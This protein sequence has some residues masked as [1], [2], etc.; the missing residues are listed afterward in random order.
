M[1]A[2]ESAQIFDLIASTVQCFDA[3][4]EENGRN[5]SGGERQRLEIACALVRSPGLLILD[6]ATSALDPLTELNVM[7]ALRKRK[8]TCLP[9]A[10]LLSTIRDCDEIIVLGG[11]R[12]IERGTHETLMAKKG[13][14]FHLV[15]QGETP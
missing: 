13:R 12:V 1:A 5:L 8:I 9:V 14:Y 6:E 15:R 10:H 11:G 2:A 4:V 3:R 7:Q